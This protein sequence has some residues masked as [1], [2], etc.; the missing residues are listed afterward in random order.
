MAFTSSEENKV[1]GGTFFIL[2]TE[3]EFGNVMLFSIILKSTEMG[4]IYMLTR[5]LTWHLLKKLLGT[6]KPLL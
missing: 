4:V 3:V 2:V 6:S 5:Y 1:R